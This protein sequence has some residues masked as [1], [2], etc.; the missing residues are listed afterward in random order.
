M[1]RWHARLLYKA[2][3]TAGV[4]ARQSTA[5]TALTP[6]YDLVASYVSTRERL[7]VM[8]RTCG[9]WRRLS[10]AGGGWRDHVDLD[11]VFPAQLAVAGAAVTNVDPH[12]HV[13]AAAA[14]TKGIRPQAADALAT[15]LGP[16]MIG[17]GSV[18]RLAMS[19]CLFESWLKGYTPSVAAAGDAPRLGVW[20]SC[21]T[22]RIT[23]R[24]ADSEWTN[25]PVG[26]RRGGARLGR[27]SHVALAWALPS[28]TR[29]GLHTAEFWGDAHLPEVASLRG[30]RVTQD[31]KVAT[32]YVYMPHY[33]L[34]R[35]LDVLDI[36]GVGVGPLYHEEKAR[37]P[38]L[39]SLA[40]QGLWHP[41]SHRLILRAALASAVPALKRLSLRSASEDDLQ[42]LVA[43]RVDA[44]PRFCS[45]RL[46]QQ[47]INRPLTALAQLPGLRRLD[48]GVAREK[49]S[50][51][52]PGEF[53]LWLTPLRS[54]LQLEHLSVGVDGGDEVLFLGGLS[55]D[56][57]LV[58]HYSM[59]NETKGL[60]PLVRHLAVAGTLVTVNGT[61]WR[62]WLEL[63]DALQPPRPT[64]NVYVCS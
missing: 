1:R 54:L 40:C 36:D 22:L 35:R 48:L 21:R 2:T 38:A 8:E 37:L 44:A 62:R 47:S 29:L 32:G 49:L 26:N 10:R 15:L 45:L 55:R 14:A 50:H 12:P 5:P 20:G 61:P 3:R 23:A 31:D 33:P 58:T 28:L 11:W 7:L 25:D 34:L 41:R 13:V 9:E 46:A 52:T 30:L 18:T 53:A 64:S 59:A 6:V 42:H 27:V 16:R 19:A 56:R 57:K 24:A 63:R 43:L 39:Q 4:A 51:I 17:R 60:P